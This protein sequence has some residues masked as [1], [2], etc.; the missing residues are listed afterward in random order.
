M[1]LLMVLGFAVG[2]S[3]SE[4]NGNDD[5]AVVTKKK[6]NGGE[7]NSSIDGENGGSSGKQ[8]ISGTI[9]WTAGYS[10]GKAIVK[11]NNDG[12]NYTMYCIDKKGNILFELNK[13]MSVG[14]DY[15]FVNGMFELDGAICDEKG[16]FTYPNDVGATKFC[17]CLFESGYIIAEANEYT[18]SATVNKMG[19]MNTKFEWVI[20]PSEDLYDEMSCI[21]NYNSKPAIYYDNVILFGDGYKKYIDLNTKKVGNTE[22]LS[23]QI[24]S[25]M[26]VRGMDSG[27]YVE[28]ITRKTVLELPYDNIYTTTDF[29]NGKSAVEFYND[30]AH[31]YYFSLVDE[32]GK[33]LFEPNEVEGYVESITFDEKNIVV[34]S[35]QAMGSTK[36]K[37]LIYD[38]QGKLLHEKEIDGYSLSSEGVICIGEKVEAYSYSYSFY[39]MNLEPL[40]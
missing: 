4:T 5:D 35:K 28:E 34:C 37:I 38:L 7:G 1:A 16:K 29:I 18:Y 40:F 24:P 33:L 15:R 19:I 14:E 25:S 22:E 20:G 27:E 6:N 8:K 17:K 32:S 36:G 31:K 23:L 2:C 13:V 9:N 10:D 26:W 30:D 21:M 39:D 12:V 3:D 11:V